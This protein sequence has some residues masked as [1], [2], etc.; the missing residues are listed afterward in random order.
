MNRKWLRAWQRNQIK[1]QGKPSLLVGQLLP[2]VLAAGLWL[3]AGS[4]VLA[5]PVDGHIVS[6]AGQI[7][8][9]G[10]TTTI[11]Q[12][13]NSLGI[14]WQGFSIG[15]TETVTFLQP[16]S[17]AVALNRVLGSNPSAIYGQLQAN[18]RVFLINP[19]GV[20]FAPG[21]Q[22]NVGGLVASTL[23]IS[24]KDFQE[25]RY[26]FTGNSGASV[27]NKGTITADKGGYVALLGT[28]V[29]NQGTILANQGTVALAGGSAVTLDFSGDGLLSVAVDAKAYQA[30][31][32]NGG[33]IQA[34]GGQ[35]LLTA[36]AAH[37][38]TSTIVNNSGVIQATRVKNQNGQIV[39]EALGGNAVNSGTL[40]VSGTGEDQTGGTVKVLSDQ[41]VVLTG[42]ARIQASGSLGGGTVLV[43]GNVQGQGTERTASNATMEAGATITADALH[44]GN[45]G[46]VVIWSEGTTRVAG[47]IQAKGGEQ[48]GNGGSV[49][50]SG[51]V[52]LH[53]ADSASVVTTAPKGQTGH[54]LLDPSDFTIANT[55][56]DMTAAALQAALATSDVT[57][58]TNGSVSVSGVS[59]TYGGHTGT[60][61]GNIY[62]NS[63]VSW[64]SGRNLTLT[65]PAGIHINAEITNAGSGRLTLTTGS[66]GYTLGSSGKITL[67][68]N[69]AGF[70][71]NGENYIVINDYSGGGALQALQN[72]KDNLSGRYILGIDV[73]ATGTS[74]WNDSAGFVPIG[75]DEDSPFTGVFDGGGHRVEGLTINR[76]DVFNIGLFGVSSGVLRNVGLTNVHI[77]GG[78]YV[79]GLAGRNYA[80]NGTASIA[81]S[82]STGTVLGTNPAGTGCIGGLVGLNVVTG[83]GTASIT[84]SYSEVNVDGAGS[85]G[86]LV[87]VN[88]VGDASASSTGT[89]LISNSY[90]TGRVAGWGFGADGV[91]TRTGIAGGLVGWNYNAGGTLRITNS[92]ST[93]DVSGYGDV[94]GLIGFN[95]AINGGTSSITNSYSTG[96]VVGT[97]CVGGLVGYNSAI[98]GTISITN[99]YSTGSVSGDTSVGGLV[100]ANFAAS[101]TASIAHSY[102]TGTVSVA[103]VPRP[104]TDTGVGDNST[105]DTGTVSV[106]NTTWDTGK[107][108]VSGTLP[109]VSSGTVGLAVNGTVQTGATG[110]IL[111]ASGFF[112]VPVTSTQL[113]PGS[114]LLLHADSQ[115]ATSVY[116]L[117]AGEGT[118]LANGNTVTGLSLS[119]HTLTVGGSGISDSAPLT[120]AQLAAAKGSSPAVYTVTE[121]N[122][123][124][125]GGFVT[126][127]GVSYQPGGNVT[128][129]GDQ[130]YGG[131]LTLGGDRTLCT[132]GGKL[133]FQGAVNGAGSTLTLNTGGG[134]VSQDSA[135]GMAVETLVLNS[136]SGNVSL[137]SATNQI[138][139]LQGTLGSLALQSD[140][141]L[142]IGAS[143]LHASGSVAITTTADNSQV[144]GRENIT[145]AGTV[146]IITPAA[147]PTPPAA[148]PTPPTPPT[149]TGTS[150]LQ[151]DRFRG[152][153]GNVYMGVR[154]RDMSFFAPIRLNPTAQEPLITLEPRDGSPTFLGLPEDS[155]ES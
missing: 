110:N 119:A 75:A 51:K 61:S 66:S 145:A 98:H 140:P 86:G 47:T 38:L 116:V 69:G 88:Q 106:T 152:A 16:S 71:L 118:M 70:T 139:H 101:G 50:T 37:D 91:P 120:N 107:S 72:V 42:T 53:I 77:I 32:Q 150:I 108:I 127:P 147:P 94:G 128:T 12:T 43:G 58:S 148:P 95:Y 76:L 115:A 64:S 25:G 1:Q 84:N 133:L 78:N 26:T 5:A 142:T 57:I 65:S 52:S 34:Q 63:P 136:G 111:D 87:G 10:T 13:S 143:G 113:T 3:F 20:L 7:Q 31:V 93:G 18:G 74:G 4:T 21:S 9:T 109:G 85:V 41:Q 55:G 29:Q 83:S 151:S 36:A 82:Y 30:A 99:S 59:G 104:G 130:T 54:W 39:L 73:D 97:D 89:A 80:V 146:S 132:G 19:N 129:T 100:G 112:F 22:V 137:T 35:V 33:L 141:S 46:Q 134:S 90:S 92:Y 6:G 102:S 122:L 105:G 123:S 14:N 153:I 48:G 11:T 125:D 124:V 8:Q 117:G 2:A 126:L 144:Y 49:E 24:D 67:S 60:D 17:Q 68:G 121:G 56:G 62:V 81:N 154:S 131:A 149:P 138:N 79:G 15:K 40:Q 155:K 28:Q 27:V 96:N 114:S 135:G 103:G 45:G 44:Q 23:S